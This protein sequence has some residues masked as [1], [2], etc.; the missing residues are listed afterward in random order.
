MATIEAPRAGIRP[1]HEFDGVY[2]VWPRGDRLEAIRDAAADSVSAS[3]HRRT[4]CARSRPSTWR[5]PATRP[6]AL[7]GAAKALNP[8]INIINRLVI[9]QFEDFEGEPADAGLGADGRG[10]RRRGAVLRPATEA[11]RRV[12]LLQGVCEVLQHG[13][14]GDRA[15]AASR[16]RTSTT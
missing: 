16:Q 1:F 5:R 11:L 15:L 8:Y 6:F 9:V 13:R 4:V 7:P 14:G 3:R 12:P 2:D 10:G